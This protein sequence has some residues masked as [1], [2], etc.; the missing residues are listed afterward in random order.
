[1]KLAMVEDTVL[2]CD[3]LKDNDNLLKIY[4]GTF[5]LKFCMHVNR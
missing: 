1:M 5:M 2:S 4:T 3:C